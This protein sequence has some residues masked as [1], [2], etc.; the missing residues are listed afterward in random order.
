[1]QLIK[2]NMWNANGAKLG[3]GKTFSRILLCIRKDALGVGLIEPQTAIDLLASKLCTGN[4]RT[5]NQLGKIIK[6]H[7]EK[8]YWASGAPVQKQIKFQV[9]EYWGSG[10][11]E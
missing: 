10:W 2:E 1:M 3:L 9:I 11:T 8:G 6:I 5:N 7:E 4:Q